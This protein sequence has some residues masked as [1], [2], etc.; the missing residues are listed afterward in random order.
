M[1][2]LS[3]SLGAK[4]PGTKVLF[5][6]EALECLKQVHV[7]RTH[8]PRRRGPHQSL[9]TAPGTLRQLLE[10]L[11]VP[12]YDLLKPLR[13]RLSTP[14]KRQ[15]RAAIRCRR[16]SRDADCT[17]G[18]WLQDALSL[19]L[20]NPAHYVQRGPVRAGQ[21]PGPSNEIFQGGRL[22]SQKA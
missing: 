2:L 13:F 8:Q 14:Q 16:R 5:I 18:D 17:L 1:K 9:K 15:L 6:H 7:F 21:G 20:A 12:I 4:L 10:L 19:L 22:T 11:D 3:L